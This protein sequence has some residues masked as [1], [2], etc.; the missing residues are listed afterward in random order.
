MTAGKA[1]TDEKGKPK[2]E[3]TPGEV[4]AIE[5]MADQRHDGVPPLTVSEDGQ[6]ITSAHR[7]ELAGMARLM[8]AVGTADLDFM[9]GFI[10]QLAKSDGGEINEQQLNFKFAVVKGMKPRDQVEAMLAG[11]MAAIHTATMRSARSLA[12]AEHLDQHDSAERTFNKLT[13]T[14]IS[15]MEAFKRYRTGGEQTVTVQQVNVG[16]GGQAIVG[17]VTQGHRDVLPNGVPAQPLALAHDKTLPMEVLE[18]REPVPVAARRNQKKKCP[19]LS[20][21]RCGARTRSGKPC[22]SPAV[23]GKKRCRMHGGAAGSGA[24]RGNRN[25]QKHGLYTRKVIAERRQVGE[26]MR[27]SR[28]LILEIE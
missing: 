3:R 15:Q 17:N 13:R 27:Q 14:F 5:K 4:A 20:S 18:G 1:K 10:D 11:Q 25:A 9:S 2:W 7:D 8:E 26:L 24:P 16:E 12:E 6:K 19:M 21:Q 22:Q 23:Q 28:K